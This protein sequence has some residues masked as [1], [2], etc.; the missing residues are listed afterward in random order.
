M[1]G[2]I[3][4]WKSDK[5]FG[6]IR[7]QG[8]GSDVFV[9]IRDFGSISRPPQVGDIVTYQPMKGADGRLRAADAHIAG[10]PRLPPTK[11]VARR[12]RE[13]NSSES[14]VPKTVGA[15]V[16]IV[17]VVIAYSILKN[18]TVARDMQPLAEQRSDSPKREYHC[19]GK[20]YCSE[21]SSCAEAIY[22][23]RHCPTTEMD[24]DGD[25]LPCESQWCN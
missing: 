25:G 9:H 1:R 10:L 5:G 8:G 15:L 20:H 7:P 17:F 18:R 21:M 6:F 3:V 14:V 23:L 4:T 11:P 19:E 2:S 13:S 12:I 24:G 22:Y 16:M